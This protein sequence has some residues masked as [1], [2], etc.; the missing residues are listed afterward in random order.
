MVVHCTRQIFLS[1]CRQVKELLFDLSLKRA[2][3]WNGEEPTRPLTQPV[4]GTTPVIPSSAPIDAHFQ[5]VL[6]HHPQQLSANVTHPSPQ[7]HPV[8][9]Q[10]S[11]I[12]YPSPQ[13][14]PV[15]AQSS[16]ITYPSPQQHPVVAPSS[17][18]KRPS[19]QQHPQSSNVMYPSPQQHPQSS[20][21]MHPSPQQHPQSSNVKRPS[22]QQHPV[23]A[24]SS[25]ITYPFPQQ[26]SVM[27]A[28][29][30]NGLNQHLP[31]DSSQFNSNPPSQY[32]SLA[33]PTQQSASTFPIN[34]EQQ[35]VFTQPTVSSQTQVCIFL[36]EGAKTQHMTVLGAI[37]IWC[38]PIIYR[39]GTGFQMP[40]LL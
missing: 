4:Q 39:R 28:N 20:N 13:Q 38:T 32:H 37:Q 34:S 3:K 25:N 1:P 5:P 23:M 15:V 24:R 18:V 36:G 33:S 31:V 16:N 10:S 26:P 30:P 12:T 14:H 7:Q 9:A 19:P 21:V 35:R 22:P 40:P 17:N 11:N 29:Y 8:M 6:K 2:L 27:T